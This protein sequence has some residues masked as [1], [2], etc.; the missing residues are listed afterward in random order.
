MDGTPEAKIFKSGQLQAISFPAHCN[1]W[2]E[3]NLLIED[4]NEKIYN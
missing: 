1:F 3:F 2:I 4:K